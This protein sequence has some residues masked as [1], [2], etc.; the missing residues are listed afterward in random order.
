[1]DSSRP[2]SSTVTEERSGDIL[3]PAQEPEEIFGPNLEDFASSTSILLWTHR[4]TLGRFLLRGTVLVA[5]LVLLIP[6]RYD[7][8]VRLMPPESEST[9]LAAVAALASGRG[10]DSM[11]GLVSSV[12]GLKMTG[13]LWIGVL[14]SRTIEDHLVDHFDLRKVY[15]VSKWEDARK[16]L[17]KHTD[18]SVDRKSGIVQI[19]VS[20]RN[21]ARARDMAR[22]YVQELNQTL[23]ETSTS[24]ARREREFLEARLKV[25]KQE[26]NRAATEFSQ[27]AS[28]NSAI[29]IPEQG[30][31][32]LNAAASLQAELIAVQSQLRGLEQIYTPDN[33]RVKSMQARVTEIE[34]QLE[35]LGGSAD[36]QA[37]AGQM[38][39]PIRQLPL[40][41]VK[42][43]D[44]YRQTAIDEAVYEFL[45]K[46]YELAK[47][48]EAK[49]LPTAKVLDPAA[50]A[51]RKS[52]PPRILLIVLG[53]IGSLLLASAWIMAG[54]WWRE[55]DSADSRKMLLQQIGSE[56]N[57]LRRLKLPRLKSGKSPS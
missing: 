28:K 43:A 32:M 29:D 24:S 21:S 3:A 7:S 39:P 51:E 27:F 19:T 20:D 38:Y 42:Y 8:T 26:W 4:K 18:I 23:S 30:K 34:R 11:G 6:N 50:V 13:D 1:M 16:E 47:V 14:Q 25:V 53:A 17:E 52:W 49:E 2:S 44:L 41:G 54:S 45:T 46:Q 10:G 37:S 35:K 55:T 33:V 56:L 31:A 40:L 48:Q 22:A 5:I 57:K 36:P 9:G 15:W 12:L